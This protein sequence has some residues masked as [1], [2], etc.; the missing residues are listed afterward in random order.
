MEARPS[1][2]SG[3]RGLNKTYLWIGRP[4]LYKGFQF[5]LFPLRVH[6][7]KCDV[8]AKEE[9]VRL[10]DEAEEALGGKVDILM[11]NAGVPPSAS[12]DILSGVNL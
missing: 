7:A 11:N 4:A 6:F 1:E 10:W 2:T 9:W 8:T 5:I 3:V 12:L